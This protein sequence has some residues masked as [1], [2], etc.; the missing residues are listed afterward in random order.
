LEK[1]IDATVGFGRL[2]FTF[3]HTSFLPDLTQVNLTLLT[4]CD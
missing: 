4:L 1:S 3:F 2:V